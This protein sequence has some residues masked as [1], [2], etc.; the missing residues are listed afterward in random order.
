[1]HHTTEPISFRTKPGNASERFL[2]KPSELFRTLMVLALTAFTNPANAEPAI[3]DTGKRETGD[4]H[5]LPAWDYHASWTEVQKGTTGPVSNDVVLEGYSFWISLH[6]SDKN[7]VFSFMK[8]GYISTDWSGGLATTDAPSR[9]NE[10]YR[11]FDTPG[12]Y[13]AYGEGSQSHEILANSESEI[14]VR[15]HSFPTTKRDGSWVVTTDYRIVKGKRWV[16][17]RPINQASELGFHGE[18]KIVVVPDGNGPGMDFVA[19]AY[20][21]ADGKVGCGPF[22]STVKMFL[23]FFM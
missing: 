7:A 1:M 15:S 10:M 12:G 2:K 4:F 16:E 6:G 9:K 18:T 3:W 17:V 11:S 14:V 8:G 20:D 23:D 13:R 22:P 19:D 5:G 21:F